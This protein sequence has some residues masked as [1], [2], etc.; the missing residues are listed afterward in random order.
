MNPPIKRLFKKPYAKELF[1]IAKGDLESA[2]GLAQIKIGRKEN[3]V[4]MVQ[5]SVEKALKALLVHQQIAFPLVHDLGTL[6]ALLPDALIPPAGFQL[7]ELNPYAAV[8][9]YEEG[10]LPLTEEEIE[11]AIVAGQGVLDWV[12]QKLQ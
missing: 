9:R 10:R 1:S 12:E 3:I 7:I 4:Y 8:R 2:R 6:I 11:I 5:Q